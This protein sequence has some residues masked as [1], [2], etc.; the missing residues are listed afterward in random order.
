MELVVA[1]LVFGIMMAMAVGI[2]SPAAKIFV[3]M[4]KLQYARLILDN[5]VQE[6]RGM[7]RGATQYVK[8]YSSCGAGDSLIGTSGAGSGKGLEFLNTDGYVVLI[9]T[10]GCPATDIYLG[11]EKIGNIGSADVESGRLLERYFVRGEGTEYNYQKEDGTYIAR[12]YNKTF[13]DRYYMGNYLD[14]EFSYGSTDAEG[15]V[16][17]LKADIALYSDSGKTQLVVKDSVVLDLRYDVK[18][19]D[20]STAGVMKE[21]ETP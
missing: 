21:E 18:K 2:L 13:A 20:G 17:S 8:I 6:L 5:T 3:R 15:N 1:L 11:T 16:K 7:A 19:E 12:A 14:V 4:Q 9:S 10:E